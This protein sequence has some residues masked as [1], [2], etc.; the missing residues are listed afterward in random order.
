[1]NPTSSNSPASLKLPVSAAPVEQKP[2]NKDCLAEMRRSPLF[3]RHADANNMVAPEVANS[4]NKPAGYFHVRQEDNRNDAKIAQA[5]AIV[6][7]ESQEVLLCT[8]LF[9]T[10]SKNVGDYTSLKAKLRASGGV[11]TNLGNVATFVQSSVG[12]NT[13]RVELMHKFACIMNLSLKK[14]V[15]AKSSDFELSDK[16]KNNKWSTQVTLSTKDIQNFFNKYIGVKID[17]NDALYIAAA[18]AHEHEGGV[19]FSLSY[20]SSEESLTSSGSQ[21]LELCGCGSY[22]EPFTK[23]AFKDIVEDTQNIRSSIFDRVLTHEDSLSIDSQASSQ[24]N[25]DQHSLPLDSSGSSHNKLNSGSLFAQAA[26]QDYV[27]EVKS[28]GGEKNNIKQGIN[29]SNSGS[30]ENLLDELRRKQREKGIIS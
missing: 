5:P 17:H 4:N 1:M 16:T 23:D 28:N 3:L 30:T 25:I 13:A 6:E 26:Q 15:N 22:K 24:N 14:E 19:R 10:S 21:F 27:E 11:S 9:R 7:S 20:F 29:Q 18:F 12:E 8:N 2:E